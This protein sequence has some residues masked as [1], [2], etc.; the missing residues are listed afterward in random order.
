MIYDRWTLHIDK[1]T[2]DFLR[3]FGSLSLSEL[4]WKPREDSWSIAQNIDHL[5]VINN[6]YFPLVNGLRTGEFK[7]H[8]IT[9][10]KFVVDRSGQYLLEGVQPDITKKFKTLPMWQPRK[11]VPDNDLL[12]E[13]DQ[14]QESLKELIANSY[15]LLDQ[16]AVIS[17]PANRFIVYKLST[18]Y[19]I[20]LAHEKRHFQ[21][22]ACVL[23][24]LEHKMTSNRIEFAAAK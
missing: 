21:Q 7:P 5:I 10:F 20:I 17:S 18:A 11:N 1:V 13:F 2:S 6:S 16:E 8:F 22:A 4:N 12:A 19:D 15:D 3:A 23:A 24:L 9:K 14:H